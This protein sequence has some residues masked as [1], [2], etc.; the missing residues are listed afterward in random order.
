MSDFLPD[1]S[2]DIEFWE[3]MPG[4]ATLVSLAEA[5]L[6]RF[7]LNQT[8]ASLRVVG[9]TEARLTRVV[10]LLAS[11]LRCWLSE[12]ARL[13]LLGL[14]TPLSEGW[15]SLQAR[16]LVEAV[17]CR[18]SVTKLVID[19]GDGCTC[20]MA[21]TRAIF[22]SLLAQRMSVLEELSMTNVDQAGFEPLIRLFIDPEVN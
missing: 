9:V 13:S 5:S 11:W 18:H 7:L 2:C 8:T 14:L 12:D 10:G 4:P 15:A 19:E 22:R 6:L 21:A 16:K 1:L 17:L 3:R 20:C